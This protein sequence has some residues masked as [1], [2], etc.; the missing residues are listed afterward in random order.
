M[1]GKAPAT[2]PY[3]GHVTSYRHRFGLSHKRGAETWICR[4]IVSI[5]GRSHYACRAALIRT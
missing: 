4:E 2:V 5:K 3:A 1:Q